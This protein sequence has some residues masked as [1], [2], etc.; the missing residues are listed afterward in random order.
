M[1]LLFENWQD[2]AL[3]LCIGLILYQYVIWF[4]GYWLEE[5]HTVVQYVLLSVFFIEWFSPRVPLWVRSAAAAA[6]CFL[7]TDAVLNPAAGST[8]AAAGSIAGWAR[9]FFI[10]S[11]GYTL[12]L[13]PYLWF[14]VGAWL[15]YAAAYRYVRTKWRMFGFMSLS[16]VIFSIVDS[17]SMF[18]LWEQVAV[19]VGAGLSMLVVQHLKLL[20]TTDPNGYRRLMK[21]PVPIT[22]SMITIISVALALGMLAPNIRPIV[23]DPYTAW[24]TYQGQSVPAFGK[25]IGLTGL[26][27]LNS[28][29]GYSR[30]DVSLGGSFNFDYTPVFT[31]DTTNRSY[32]RGETRSFYTG[33]GWEPTEAEGGGQ[34]IRMDQRTSYSPYPENSRLGTIQ[35]TQTFRMSSPEQT[36]PVLFAAPFPTNVIPNEGEAGWNLRRAFWHTEQGTILWNERGDNDY[37]LTYTVVSEM[38]VID[39]PLLR[40][41]DLDYNRE[42]FED[43][44]QLPADLPDR[45]RDLAERVTAQADNPYDKAMALKTYLQTTFP[46]TNDPDVSKKRSDDF[47][48]SFLFEIQEGYCDYYSSA[49][50]VMARSLDF[51][52]RWVKGYSS[53]QSDADL[54]FEQY[55][56]G[57]EAELDGPGIY[58][59]RNSDAHSWVEVYFNGFGWIPFEPTANFTLP[60]IMGQQAEEMTLPELAELTDQAAAAGAGSGKMSKW[61][62]VAGVSAL[63]FGVLAFLALRYHWITLLRTRSFRKSPNYSLKFLADMERLLIR[64]RRRG[65]LW[66]EHET[67]REMMSRWMKEHARLQ[68]DFQ[69]LLAAF[70]KA[71]YSQAALTAEEYASAEQRMR[72]LRENL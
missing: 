44:L 53:G 28:A 38:P 45:V 33:E 9:E 58:T 40:T 67:V 42:R 51:P 17:F 21:Y 37:P 49:M 12:Q 46:Y 72:H 54:I 16:V 56:P 59:V 43:Y 27:E 11:L 57:D 55:L 63:A 39:E 25:G 3:R 65:L 71:K 64:L 50:V 34:L 18:I 62:A 7:V 69:E 4:A 6:A 35:V 30:N 52:A 14:A 19:I 24:K 48:D 60:N 70:E 29:S 68:P 26:Y 31:V 23:V 36:F 41:A 32:W 2:K 47:V 61:M 5:T 15:A 66:S 10:G 22:V 1:K 8:A 13:M 20:K